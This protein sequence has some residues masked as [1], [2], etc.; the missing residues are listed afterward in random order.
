MP[1]C[2]L[3][4][5]EIYEHWRYGLATRTRKYR[6]LNFEK[7]DRFYFTID[8]TFVQFLGYFSGSTDIDFL[9]TEPD[10]CSVLIGSVAG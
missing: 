2:D 5:E 8:S 10:V 1:T 9:F 3:F 7:F 6:L 4:T